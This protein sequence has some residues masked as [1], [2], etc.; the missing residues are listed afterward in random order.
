MK[1]S[2]STLACPDWS[3]SDIYSM[4]KD[5]KFDGIELRG[6]GNEIFSVK[7]Q[8][9]TD[10]QLPATIA[11][12]KSLSLEIPCLDSGACLKFKD[13]YAEAEAEITAYAQLANKIGASYIRILADLGPKPVDEV[14]DDYI[15]ETL[16]K[17]VPVAE[18]YNVTLL[19]E[20]NGVYSNTARLAAVLEKVGSRKVAALWDMHHPYRFGGESPEQT[21]ANLGEYIKFI[22][23]KDSVVGAD[24]NVEYRIMGSGD[25]PVKEMITALEAINYNG[26]ISLEWV[27]RWARDLSDAGI[28]IPQF[29]E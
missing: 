1:I 13:K 28:V 27:K 8:P 17:L 15:V 10:S 20:T 4:A 2:F 5:F 9:F 29:A 16:K 19:V 7:A 6:L 12:L 26:Y 11:K 18:E 25:I 24:G 23:V 3:W 14:D 22:Q 21:V